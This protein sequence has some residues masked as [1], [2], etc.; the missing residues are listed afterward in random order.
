LLT[1]R[2]RSFVVDEALGVIADEE[3]ALADELD[4]R[5]SR[6][7]EVLPL[8]TSHDGPDVRE[9]EHRQRGKNLEHEAFPFHRTRDRESD[10]DVHLSIAREAKAERHRRPGEDIGDGRTELG[11]PR[12]DVGLTRDAQAGTENADR[13]NLLHGDVGSSHR[14]PPL[15]NAELHLSAHLPVSSMQA[16]HPA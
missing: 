3:G 5:P 12:Q 4:E 8:R 9:R 13:L 1:V 14:L 2:L 10:L 6:V 16:A 7:D 11:D 15:F